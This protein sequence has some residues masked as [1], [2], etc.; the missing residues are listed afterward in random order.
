MDGLKSRGQVV[1]MAATNRPDDL[2]E[3]LRRPGRFDRELKINPP[4]N[5][6]RLE[7][8]KIHTRNMPLEDR[9]GILDEFSKNPNSNPVIVG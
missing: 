2:D 4:T 6:G 1:V 3:A 7:I 8:L 5:E 9:E